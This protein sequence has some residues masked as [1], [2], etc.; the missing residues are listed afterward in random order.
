MAMA[1]PDASFHPSAASAA[2]SA[3]AAARADLPTLPADL[4][5]ARADP[6]TLPMATMTA[7]AVIE[8]PSA[9]RTP[10]VAPEDPSAA[11]NER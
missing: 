10:A 8:A 3:A 11:V 2:V 9:L 7:T 6:K 5:E 4:P 1:A